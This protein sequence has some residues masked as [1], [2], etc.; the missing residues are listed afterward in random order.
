MAASH[1]IRSGD[2]TVDWRRLGAF[3]S[4][5]AIYTGWF[6]MHWF[7]ALQTWFPKPVGLG[8]RVYDLR[9]RV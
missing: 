6:Q 1:P 4:F 3:A 2:F 8:F 5:G 9:F 7:R